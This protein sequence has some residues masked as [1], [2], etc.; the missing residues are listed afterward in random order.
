[1]A[2]D[3]PASSQATIA[4]PTNDNAPGHAPVAILLRDAIPPYTFVSPDPGDVLRKFGKLSLGQDERVTTGMHSEVL[5][6]EANGL[7]MESVL[8]FDETKTGKRPAVLVFPE[9]YGLSAHA[10]EKAERLAELGYV[11]LASD[12]YGEGKNANTLDEALAFVGP[13][14]KESVDQPGLCG[15]RAEGADRPARSG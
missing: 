4:P 12:L 9:A 10:K 5:K 13:M 6:Y 2:P 1:M 14:L 11:T 3:V 8:Y 15:S 7:N